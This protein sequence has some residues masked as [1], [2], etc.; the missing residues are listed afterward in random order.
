MSAEGQPLAVAAF[1][2]PDGFEEYEPVNEFARHNGPLY[3][4]ELPENG[5]VRAFRVLERHTNSGGI[6]HGGML[7]SFADMVLGHMC[8]RVQ[9]R[10]GAT[11]QLSTSFL[12]PARLGDWVEG[13][14]TL[15]RQ[16]RSLL[17]LRAEV[18]V[19]DRLILT[20]DGVFHVNM[21]KA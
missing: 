13:R 18:T 9:G 21:P 20:A 2:P 19:G 3:Q 17:F 5:F 11:V 12:A 14:G 4:K 16:T 8:R 10:A 7:V 1:V 15:L 6:C